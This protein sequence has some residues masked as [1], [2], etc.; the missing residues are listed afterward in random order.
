VAGADFLTVN[1]KRAAVGYGAIDGGDALGRGPAALSAKYSP[2]QP[3]V[4]AGSSDG[5]QWTAAGGGGDV[6]GEAGGGDDGS[7]DG[8]VGKR[9]S[10]EEGYLKCLEHCYT[11]LER[12]QPPGVDRNHWDYFRCMDKCLGR[13]S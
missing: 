5:G 3:R 10:V 2:D 1:E 9:V 7:A 12:Y 8:Q 13:S 11:L 4:P 6:G